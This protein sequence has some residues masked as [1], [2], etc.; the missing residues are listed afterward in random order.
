[1][2]TFSLSTGNGAD[3]QAGGLV[4][5]TVGPLERTVPLL[6]DRAYEDD[7]TRLTAWQLRCKAVVA[8]KRDRVYPWAYDTELFRRLKGLRCM[9][10]RYE[11]LYRMCAAFVF[12]ACI[13]ITLRCLNRP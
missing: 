3:A 4:L 5:E 8:P 7:R 11:Q 9:F 2:E 10:M 6:M 13:C 1:V 12:L